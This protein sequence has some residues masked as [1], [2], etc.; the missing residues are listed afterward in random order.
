M[1]VTLNLTGFELVLLY[2]ATG[3]EDAGRILRHCAREYARLNPEP[4]K[5]RGR[6]SGSKNKPDD[7]QE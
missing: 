4:K 1:K 5:K 2:P 7:R 3:N 6:P